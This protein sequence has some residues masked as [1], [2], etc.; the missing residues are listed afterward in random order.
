MRSH[1]ASLGIDDAA[2]YFNAGVL[3][4]NLDQ[5]RRERATDN[6]VRFVTSREALSWFDQDALNSVFAG[7]WKPLH[8][9]WNAMNS[10]WTWPD[11]AA[12]IFGTA[13]VREATSNPGILHF[14]GP[15]LSKPWHYLCPHPWRSEYRSTLVRTPWGGTALEDRTLSTMLI[16]RL[17]RQRQLAAYVRLD[18]ARQRLSA[19]RSRLVTRLRGR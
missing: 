12:D 7:R 3:V 4:V 14:E 16:A 18:H 6:L 17:P 19:I 5:W 8:P 11:L 9:R 10:L 15:S 13:A 1:L 2:R